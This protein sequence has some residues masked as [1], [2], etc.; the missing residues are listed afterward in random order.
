[1]WFCSR[2]RNE[3][4][5]MSFDSAANVCHRERIQ[6]RDLSRRKTCVTSV[7]IKRRMYEEDETDYL[8]ATA[9]SHYGGNALRT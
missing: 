2:R 8:R 3:S 6:S 7:W 9:C 4:R 5:E 1:M